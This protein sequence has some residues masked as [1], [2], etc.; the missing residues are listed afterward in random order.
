MTLAFRAAAGLVAE[1]ALF[2]LNKMGRRHHRPEPLPDLSL[3]WFT[4]SYGSTFTVGLLLLAMFM[5]CGVVQC[6]LQG[7][8]AEM[9]RIVLIY[10]PVGV[11]LMFL[12]PTFVSLLLALM[13]WFT[14]S[15][16]KTPARTSRP[17]PAESPRS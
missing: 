13:D 1:I 5:L 11:V 14:P 4:N 7:A 17:P 12:A 8:M 6:Q 15:S 9:G 2:F 10:V 16:P 3:P